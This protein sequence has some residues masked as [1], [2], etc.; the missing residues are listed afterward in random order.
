MGL[1]PVKRLYKKNLARPVHK[2]GLT[3]PLSSP[4]GKFL[5]ATRRPAPTPKNRRPSQVRKARSASLA[6]SKTWAGISRRAR[7]SP[8]FMRRKVL[9]V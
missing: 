7:A 9:A 6:V 8:S 4:F 3:Y 5:A 1:R 2:T